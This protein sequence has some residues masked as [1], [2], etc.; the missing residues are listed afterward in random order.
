[1]V[2]LV[3]YDLNKVK[4]YPDLY[5][6]IKRM[7]NWMRDTD[8][9]SVWFVSTSMSAEGIYNSLKPHIDADDRLFV[10]RVRSG[11]CQG[12]LSKE[13]WRWIESRY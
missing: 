2:Y 5:Q 11:E 12:W 8:L 7:P 1:M 13:G 10:T 9:D 4:D 3:T 6:A